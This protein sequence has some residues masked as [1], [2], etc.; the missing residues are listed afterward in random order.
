MNEI[1]WYNADTPFTTKDFEHDRWPQ[2]KV[3]THLHP[4]EYY[5]S[6]KVIVDSC[7]QVKDLISRGH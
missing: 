7:R 3:Q 6:D 2:T 4:Y 1:L 5:F